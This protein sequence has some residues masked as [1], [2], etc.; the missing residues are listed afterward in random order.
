VGGVLHLVGP[1]AHEGHVSRP[2][3]RVHSSGPPLP[4]KGRKNPP[5]PATGGFSRIPVG[6]PSA[7]ADWPRGKKGRG[8]EG[9]RARSHLWRPRDLSPKRVLT[10]AVW[11]AAPFVLYT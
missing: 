4:I 9:A 8:E 5:P 3:L 10:S 11:A 1:P 7:G 6:D 2:V